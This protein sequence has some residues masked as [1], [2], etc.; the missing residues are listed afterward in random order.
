MSC[1]IGIIFVRVPAKLALKLGSGI[2]FSFTVI[3]REIRGYLGHFIQ[4]V[5]RPRISQIQ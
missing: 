4:S 1:G 2:I 3:V 5:S